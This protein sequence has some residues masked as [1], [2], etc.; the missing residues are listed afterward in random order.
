M[1]SAPPLTLVLALLLCAPGYAQEAPAV[2]TP[3]SIPAIV[4]M[5]E[6]E[7]SAKEIVKRS[8]DLMRGDTQKVPK[9]GATP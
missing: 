6:P 9:R 3:L 5:A 1:K 2:R 7:L 4:F 8:D